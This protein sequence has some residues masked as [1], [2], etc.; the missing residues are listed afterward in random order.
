M[1]LNANTACV[2]NGAEE[3]R[4]LQCE[5]CTNEAA[6]KAIAARFARSV[7]LSSDWWH[8]GTKERFR[9]AE[10]LAG[11]TRSGNVTVSTEYNGHG[12]DD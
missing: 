2:F 10:L 11:A 4:L 9:A 7:L 5:P 3:C 8:Y 1:A 12:D 6:N